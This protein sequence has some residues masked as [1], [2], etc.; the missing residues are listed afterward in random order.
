[1]ISSKTNYTGGR[2][3]QGFITQLSLSLQNSVAHRNLSLQA[4]IQD[5]A[6][7]RCVGLLASKIFLIKEAVGHF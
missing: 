6:C 1:M 7:M 5:M 4:R 2:R 3:E